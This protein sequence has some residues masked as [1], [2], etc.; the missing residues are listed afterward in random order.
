MLAASAFG[1]KKRI[2]VTIE[3]ATARETLIYINGGQR[4]LQVRMAPCN[5]ARVLRAKVADIVE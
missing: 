4:G 5:V 3:A 2:P 1:Q